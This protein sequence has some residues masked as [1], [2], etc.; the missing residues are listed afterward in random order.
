MRGWVRDAAIL[1][2]IVAAIVGLAIWIV[3]GDDDDDELAVTETE[4]SQQREVVRRISIALRDSYLE[5]IESQILD[6]PEVE[7]LIDAIEQRLAV[8]AISFA[9]EPRIVAVADGTVNAFAFPGGL[10][11]I[12]AG[13]VAALDEPEQLA[14]VVAHEL[15]HVWHQDAIRQAM[16]AIGFAAVLTLAGGGSN[17]EQVVDRLLAELVTLHFSRRIE[18]RADEF[19]HRMLSRAAISPRAFGD[20]LEAIRATLPEP[21]EDD[22][23]PPAGLQ[24]F[25]S[26]PDIDERIEAAVRAAEAT[27]LELRP[28]TPES[29]PEV[30]ERLALFGDPRTKPTTDS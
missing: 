29:W 24:Y 10:V 28:F 23:E 8:D 1:A 14:A 11:L 22:Q 2:A 4:S 21:E 6:D 5:T 26:H 27:E 17:I 20:A 9:H 16:R 13:L 12:H 30:K 25:A 3:P 19:A 7:Q 15:G 18:S